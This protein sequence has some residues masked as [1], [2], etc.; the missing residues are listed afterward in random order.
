[1]ESIRSLAAQHQVAVGIGSF[2]E[3]PI[4]GDPVLVRRL[5]LILL[6]NAIK[7]TPV[8]GDV[9][10]DVTVADSRRLV[11]IT[12]TGVGIPPED[13][14][15][16]FERF[17]RSDTARQE[18]DGAGLGL[19]IA[20]WIADQHGATLGVRSKPGAGTTVTVSFPTGV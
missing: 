7:F 8:G 1:V 19:A 12:D 15:R 10:L 2:E 18:T 17:F 3:A 9:R 6:D 16:V 5:L 13:L 20:R 11:T 4:T 14:S